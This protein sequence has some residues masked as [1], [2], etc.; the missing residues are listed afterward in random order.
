[1]SYRPRIHDRHSIRLRGYDY[2]QPE[3][4]RTSQ[5][6][7]QLHRP[8]KS[9]GSFIAGFKSSVTSRAR[10]ELRITNVWQRNDY[11]HIIRSTAEFDKIWAYIDNG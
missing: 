1:M 6:A 5:P 2:S 10:R 11:E 4:Q 3:P 7:P 9:L 8:P